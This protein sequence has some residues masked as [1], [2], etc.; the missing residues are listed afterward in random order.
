M[1]SAD[2]V[3]TRVGD[4]PPGITLPWIT[5][6]G[7]REG[8]RYHAPVLRPQVRALIASTIVAVVVLAA[9][10]A[11][12]EP[13]AAPNTTVA[14]TS[15]STD[16][17]VTPGASD[18][19][20]AAPG[21]TALDD[22]PVEAI[23][24]VPCGS[25]RECATY[26]VPADYSDPQG[27]TVALSVIRRPATG[28]DRIG[29]LFMNP[30]GPGGSG[31]DYVRV[32]ALDP[33]L[34]QYFDIVSWD[35]RGVG[36]S[37]PIDCDD[38]IDD[39]RAADWEPDDDAEQAEL[40]QAAEAIADECAAVYGDRLGQVATE[41][42][43]RD[44]DRLRRA[45]GD[46]ALSYI[47]F[48]YGTILGQRYAELFPDRVRAMV[49]D[50]VVDPTQDLEELLTGQA[51]AFEASIDQSFAACAAS[52]SCAVIDPATSY[53]RLAA[54]VEVEP[55]AVPGRDPVGPTALAFA[56][57]SSAYDPARADT[58]I[59]ALAAAERG[60]GSPLR[61]LADLYFAS[62]GYTEYASVVCTDNPHPVGADEHRAM[63]ERMA[64]VA[65]RFGASIAS[66]MAP[67]A[68][69]DA[70]VT[71][72]PGPITAAGAPPILV[73]GNTGDAATPFAAAERVAD[74][75]E[76][77]VLLTHRGTGHTS[78]NSDACVRQVVQLY[79]VDLA[80]PDAGT[81]CPTA[82]R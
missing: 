70:P 31:V 40:D 35:P 24:W 56:A 3:G 37:E 45:V 75:L 4:D 68:F 79:L 30:G 46:E 11:A 38:G 10:C 34:N 49:L 77:G 54:Q 29:S 19:P 39:L 12:Q 20:S 44:L 58:F 14:A 42:T 51:I 74:D 65:P 76:S 32:S 78:F 55:L 8:H 28:G 1:R 53:D 57:L 50:G 69:W 66:E 13:A 59:T 71:G 2:G 41:A 18:G 36:A 25:G 9:S 62:T 48:S 60:D 23:D 64:A 80:I 61:Q 67:C 82:S 6:P 47:G 16:P 22:G 63:T 21:T 81:V 72:R 52:T 15:G 17:S 43:A 73:V 27:P 7:S 5:R 33:T 26:E